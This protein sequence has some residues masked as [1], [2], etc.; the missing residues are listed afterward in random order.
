[1][2][3]GYVWYANI[4]LLVR[5]SITTFQFSQCFMSNLLRYLY[6]D[7]CSP[8]VGY[9]SVT[10]ISSIIGVI[11]SIVR[12]ICILQISAGMS[13]IPATLLFLICFIAPSIS[14][15]VD[16]FVVMSKLKS[17]LHR[18]VLLLLL[19]LFISLDHIHVNDLTHHLI[20]KCPS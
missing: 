5:K 16:L 15:F 4:L 10:Q 12:L 18:G 13:S 3:V 7:S 9:I 1:M 19:L 2:P 17:L 8:F 6:Y 11:I 20:L 14:I